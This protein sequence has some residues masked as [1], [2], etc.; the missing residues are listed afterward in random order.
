[1]N[2]ETFTGRVLQYRSGFYSVDT[3]DGVYTCQLRGRLKRGP[4]LSDLVAVG[5]QVKI[6]LLGGDKGMIEFV[7]PRISALVRLAPSARGDYQQILLANVDQIVLVFSCANPAPHLRMLDR[8]LVICEK[9]R[10]PPIIVVNKV[11]LCVREEIESLFAVYPGLG[12]PVIF[13]SSVTKE[14]VDILSSRLDGKVS[15]LVGPSGVGKSS[16]LNA[17]QPELGLKVNQVS[18]QTAKGRHTTVVREMFPLIKG[19]YVADLP[20]LRSLA[21]WDTQPEELD[22][23]F[24]E[25]KPLVEYCQF[26]DCTHDE[27]E[28]GCAVRAAVEAGKV[29]EE[30]YI[31]YLHMRFGEQE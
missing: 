20:G 18:D 6:V 19:G 15:G 26:S 27:N 1:M 29:N 13:T 28:P 21:L 16:L 7:E 31:S 3:G 12:Y 14:G 4:R 11:D 10:I 23:Y 8:F 17:I 30:R 25:L 9:Q 5:D 2:Q 24:P 22:G